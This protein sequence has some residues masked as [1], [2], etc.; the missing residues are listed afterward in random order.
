MNKAEFGASLARMMADHDPSL[1]A[2]LAGL[3]NG[4]IQWSDIEDE[5]GIDAETGNPIPN[6]ATEA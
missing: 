2:D 4:S 3:L 1:M 5:P 6:G